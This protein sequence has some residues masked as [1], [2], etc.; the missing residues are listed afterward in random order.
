MGVRFPPFAPKRPS[1]HL[2]GFPSPS[3][4]LRR[5]PGAESQK[6]T[7][8]RL[9]SDRTRL[10]TTKTGSATWSGDGAL[11][12]DPARNPYRPGAGTRPLVLAGRDQELERIDVLLRSV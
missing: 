1:N 9:E 4:Q 6:K 12:M 11:K 3:G 10:L 8:L 7:T 2:S 5:E